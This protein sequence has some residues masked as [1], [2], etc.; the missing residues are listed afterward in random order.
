MYYA[1]TRKAIHV[2]FHCLIITAFHQRLA[3]CRGGLLFREHKT[4]TYTG[5]V[6]VLNSR[7]VHRYADIRRILETPKKPHESTAFEFDKK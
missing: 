5:W 6:A 1:K 4:G 3:E 2:S 7:I